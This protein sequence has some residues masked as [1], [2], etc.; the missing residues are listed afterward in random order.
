MLAPHHWHREFDVRVALSAACI[1]LCIACSASM[2]GHFSGVTASCPCSS[3]GPYVVEVPIDFSHDLAI[4]EARIRGFDRPLC[5][6]LDTGAPTTI[7]ASIAR[8]V[9]LASDSSAPVV[10]WIDAHGAEIDPNPV[11]ID[12]LSIGPAEFDQLPAIALEA[13]VFDL[14]CPPIDGLL[15]T[16]GIR[17]SDGFLERVSIEIDRDRSRLRISNESDLLVP[18]D[19]TVP[20]QRYRVAANGEMLDSSGSWIPVQADGRRVWAAL[21]TGGTGLV[22]IRRDVFEELGRSIE[23]DDVLRYVGANSIAAGGVTPFEGNWIAMLDRLEVGLIEIS[24]LPVRVIES[25]DRDLQPMLISQALLAY[26]N[27]ALDYRRSEFRLDVRESTASIIDLETQLHWTIENGVPVVIGF[28]EGGVAQKAG[29]ELGD[30]LVWANGVTIDP[31]D[32]ESSCRARQTMNEEL[33]PSRLR[34]RRGDLEFE[35][36][37][38]REEPW[39]QADPDAGESDSEPAEVPRPRPTAVR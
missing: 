24:P 27:V 28:L 7:R 20:L 35:V 26:F 29:I 14:L 17:R 25:S 2:R 32:P 34:L 22:E 18:G 23:D 12:S 39:P 16:G 6:A 4:V 5:L 1:L 30:E 13:P 36:R 10:Q 33:E 37:L 9:G 19:S 38:P 11:V 8:E 3:E 21:D 15:G 31:N